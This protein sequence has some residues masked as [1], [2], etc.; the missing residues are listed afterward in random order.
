MVVRDPSPRKSRRSS[1][2]K[3]RRR[4]TKRNSMRRTTNRRSTK[5]KSTKAKSVRKTPGKKNRK[6]SPAR[7][8]MMLPSNGRGD[9][10]PLRSLRFDESGILTRYK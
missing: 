4:K 10:N 2:R 6:V 5:R 7:V 9:F 3:S 8:R 1:S